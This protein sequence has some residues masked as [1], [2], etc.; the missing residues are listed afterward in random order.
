MLELRKLELQML[1]YGALPL[2]LSCDMFVVARFSLCLFLPI[3]F[4]SL[5]TV[6]VFQSMH[7]T[8]VMAVVANFQWSGC[9]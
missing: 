5:N 4:A 1:E 8:I 7:F 6:F 9:E 3:Q 2:P